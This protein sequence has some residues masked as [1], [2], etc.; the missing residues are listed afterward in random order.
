[1]ISIPF[2]P[3]NGAHTVILAFDDY[4]HVPR[5]KAITQASR[6][7]NIPVLPFTEDDVL[8]PNPPEPWAS[9]MANRIFK[10][11]VQELICES[12]P[13]LLE[14]PP[15]QDSLDPF[16]LIIDWRG[17][18][19]HRYTWY[20]DDNNTLHLH[21]PRAPIG[22][23]DVKLVWWAKQFQTSPDKLF[24]VEA[25]DGDYVPISLLLHDRKD[26]PQ[27]AILR[28]ECG[29]DK[30]AHSSTTTTPHRT[31][32]WVFIPRLH[33]MIQ[34]HIGEGAFDALIVLIAL[35]GT[36]FSRNLPLI[37]P[38]KITKHIQRLIRGVRS[39]APRQEETSPTPP[40]A[41]DTADP[42][43]QI[44]IDAA[45]DLVAA[46]IYALAFERHVTNIS[47]L[48]RVLRELNR[49]R[50]LSCTTKDRLPSLDQIRCTL[51]N[52]NFLLRYW[53]GQIP[54]ESIL[55]DVYGFRLAGDGHT[56]E[57]AY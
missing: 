41:E 2:C 26:S 5:A 44:D 50:S 40:P 37:G 39:C 36:D 55:P 15:H 6:R 35:T 51:C 20:A 42:A 7:R 4:A 3:R 16:T 38:K 11:R 1:M 45:L 28:M 24:A 53:N 47:S 33:E 13:Q 43:F 22:E 27:I 46:P 19:L 57:W 25:T 56:V 12:L 52:A 8:P 14:P 21:E 23:A 10:A 54:S 30:F 48:E 49:S 17:P 34:L 18:T 9:A 31:Y 29:A 32:E